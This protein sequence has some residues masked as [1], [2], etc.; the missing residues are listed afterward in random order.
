[1][2]MGM[3]K[4]DGNEKSWSKVLIQNH[5]SW[6]VIVQDIKLNVFRTSTY[7][8]AHSICKSNIILTPWTIISHPPNIATPN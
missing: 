3:C 6:K 4:I 2:E 8:I 7:N 5:N 1:M